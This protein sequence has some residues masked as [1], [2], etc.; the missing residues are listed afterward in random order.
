M[1]NLIHCLLQDLIIVCTCNISTYFC[2]ISKQIYVCPVITVYK[3]I[4]LIKTLNQITNEIIY[5]A[6][7]I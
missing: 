1:L 6:M 7:E 3:Q 4:N 5:F 2:I